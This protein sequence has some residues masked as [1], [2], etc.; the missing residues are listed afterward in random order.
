MAKSYSAT[1][2]V[3]VHYDD[4]MAAPHPDREAYLRTIAANP[5]DP[6]PRAVYADWCAEQG[7]HAEELRQRLWPVLDNPDDMETRLR[8]ADWLDLNRRRKRAAYI[9]ECVFTP[10][11]KDGRQ[12]LETC[13]CGSFP[14]NRCNVC[15][16]LGID[17]Q[18]T[19]RA[20]PLA[21]IVYYAGRGF[22][23]VVRLASAVHFPLLAKR[24]FELHPLRDVWF[25]DLRPDRG[26]LHGYAESSYVWSRDHDGRITAE[27]RRSRRWIPA[28]LWPFLEGGTGPDGVKIYESG[29]LAMD[30]LTDAAVRYGRQQASLRAWKHER[31]VG[32]DQD[33]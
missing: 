20:A 3:T 14:K 9:R 26:D 22:V 25:S 13:M 15:K 27:G 24:L 6:A 12:V 30:D 18:G 10:R 31:P 16:H 5:Y 28:V 19:M 2:G 8:F 4:P 1:V 33:D 21:R 11:T 32:V 29:R 23:E 17:D 7:L